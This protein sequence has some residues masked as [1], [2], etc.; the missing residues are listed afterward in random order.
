ML[1]PILYDISILA[2]TEYNLSYYNS[3]R[4]DSLYGNSKKPLTDMELFFLSYKKPFTIRNNRKI[5]MRYKSRVDNSKKMN[6]YMISYDIITDCI[7]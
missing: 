2:K 3:K 7:K 1:L 6:L 4:Q 5:N